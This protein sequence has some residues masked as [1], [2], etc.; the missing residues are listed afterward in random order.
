MPEESGKSNFIALPKKAG[1]NA[2]K[3]HRTNRFLNPNANHWD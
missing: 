1:Q 3:L 2:C